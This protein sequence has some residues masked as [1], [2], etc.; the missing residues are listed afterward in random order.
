METTL[1]PPNAASPPHAPT[2]P[3]TAYTCF[4]AKRLRDSWPVDVET[5]KRMELVAVEWRALG[6]QERGQYESEAMANKTLL[7]EF[8]AEANIPENQQRRLYKRE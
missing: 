1:S 6:A 2:K 7:A 4:V 3:Q 8:L 5:N